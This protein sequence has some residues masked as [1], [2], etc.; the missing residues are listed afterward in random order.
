MHDLSLNLQPCPDNYNHI[1][2]TIIV[3]RSTPNYVNEVETLTFSN[4]Q[5]F[6]NWF[7]TEACNHARWL[8]RGR[9][10]LEKP[11]LKVLLHITLPIILE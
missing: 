6:D 10:Y 3:H 5:E 4:E 1:Q 2:E 9:M 11:R 7:K 8:R